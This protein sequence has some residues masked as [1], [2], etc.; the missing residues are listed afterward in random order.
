MIKV[1]LHQTCSACPEQYDMYVDGENIGY[2]RTRHGYFMVEYLGR[3]VFESDVEGDGGFT[4]E[5]R[6]FFLEEGI[7]AVLE[8]H[9]GSGNDFSYKIL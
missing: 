1:E 2:F 9:S 5:E 8:A 4:A 7:H 3:V 6:G